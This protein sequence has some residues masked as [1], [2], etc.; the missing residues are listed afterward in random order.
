M[1]HAHAFVADLEHPV[2]D[3]TDR[4]HLERVLRLRAGDEVTVADGRGGWRVCRFGPELEPT[5]SLEHRPSAEPKLTMAFA[6]MKGERPEWTVQK[7]TEL[8]VDEIVPFVA[9]RSVV[10]WRDD[11]ADRQLERLRRVAREA[12]MQSRRAWLPEV[13]AVTTFTDVAARSGA[14]LID[15]GGTDR[16]TLRHRVLLVGP[17]GGWSDAERDCGLPAVGLGP[18][19]LRAETAAVA[20]ASVWSGLRAGIVTEGRVGR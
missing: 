9:E 13:T 10:R 2:L 19:V 11:R 7:L 3:D 1:A 20:A 15:I 12:A 5:G 6:L 18:N 4:H 16:P 14:A 8:G 17:E